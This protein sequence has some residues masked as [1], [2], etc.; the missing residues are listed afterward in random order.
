M[1]LNRFSRETTGVST[2]P[3]RLT[4]FYLVFFCQ[5]TEVKAEEVGGPR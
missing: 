1:G 4:E 5:R 3:S 2:L